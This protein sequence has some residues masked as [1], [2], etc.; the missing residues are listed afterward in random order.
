LLVPGDEGFC[1]SATFTVRDDPGLAAG[2]QDAGTNHG[3]RR[4]LLRGG[5]RTGKQGDGSREGCARQTAGQDML[6]H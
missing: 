1:G 5:V 2:Q 4:R 3:N 6:I